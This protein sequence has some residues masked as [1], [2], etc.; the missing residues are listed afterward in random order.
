MPKFA[1]TLLTSS[2]FSLSS[3][4]G[5]TPKPLTPDE[6]AALYTPL[7]APGT[8]QAVYHIG[9]SL[10]SRDMP[11]MLAQLAGEG[12]RY[13]SQL[14]WGSPLRHHWDAEIPIKGFKEENAHPRYRDAHEAVASGDY[15]VLVLTEAVEIRASL[16]YHAP[17]DYLARWSKAARTA[18]PDIRIYL[19]ESWHNTDDPEGW[20]NRLDLDLSRYWEHEI[21]D[22][23]MTVEGVAPVHVIPVGQVMARFLR[24]VEAQGGVDGIS[25]VDDLF[26]D[27]I[28]PNDIGAY[29]VALTHYAVIYGR[30]PLGL[31]H[32]LLLHTGEAAAAPSDE[33]AA[34]MQEIVWEVVTGYART[35]VSP[36]Q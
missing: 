28:H 32:E 13:E 30:S 19:Y 18:N 16:K 10:V 14:G 26:S 5:C 27:R 31:P 22:R 34:L 3:L 11:A 35:G 20:L 25:G 9:H 4:F 36:A 12:H 24:A 33:A 29:L 17:W 15:D 6:A 1:T 21:I 23:A 2:L 7:P 8:P